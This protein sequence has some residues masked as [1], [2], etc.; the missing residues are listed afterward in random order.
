M[1]S[2]GLYEK[3]YNLHYFKSDFSKAIELYQEII[4]D[5]PESEEAGY[6]KNQIENIENMGN[7]EKEKLK[8]KKEKQEGEGKTH[9][10]MMDR[11]EAILEAIMKD[12]S[13]M[14]K[15]IHTI[16]TIVLIWFILGLIGILISVITF[17]SIV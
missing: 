16:S 6:S 5:F 3:A 14:G 11:Q 4:K 8:N 12:I 10:S 17:L 13:K 15:D 1:D 9:L 2:K 7:L